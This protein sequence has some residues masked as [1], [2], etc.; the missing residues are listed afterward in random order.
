MSFSHLVLLGLAALGTWACAAA[1][2]PRLRR[3]AV[4]SLGAMAL[5]MAGG[6]AGRVLGIGA[7]LTLLPGMVQGAAPWLRAH[8]VASTL[9]MAAVL[10]AL[11]VLN[12]AGFCGTQA[13]PLLT[14]AGIPTVLLGAGPMAFLPLTVA[15]MG[16]YARLGLVIGLHA[17]RRR[18]GLLAEI[19]PMTLATLGMGVGLA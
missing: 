9:T 12:G 10:A 4:L 11:F 13:L 7:M 8:R 5:A 15:A 6:T 1:A 17:L 14:P 19:A 16:V 3:D 18:P 2:P